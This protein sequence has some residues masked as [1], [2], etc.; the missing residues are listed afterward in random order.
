MLQS[1]FIIRRRTSSDDVFG[2]Q[3]PFFLTFVFVLRFGITKKLQLLFHRNIHTQMH[4]CTLKLIEV[5]NCFVFFFSLVVC[6][7]KIQ[8]KHI[9][10]TVTFAIT[11]LKKRKTKQKYTVKARSKQILNEANAIIMKILP[12]LFIIS[13]QW[14]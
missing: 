7:G 10:F 13:L 9:C 1:F 8:Y 14:K 6:T 5:F 4:V 11:S 2:S 3:P 12:S